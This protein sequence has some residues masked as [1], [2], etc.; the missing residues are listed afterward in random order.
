MNELERDMNPHKFSKNNNQHGGP[1]MAK[2]PKMYTTQLF[3]GGAF[4]FFSIFKPFRAFFKP[5]WPRS[6]EEKI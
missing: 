2:T 3:F 5:F 1:V 4:I 6:G